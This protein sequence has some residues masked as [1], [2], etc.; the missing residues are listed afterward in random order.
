MQLGRCRAWV[1]SLSTMVHFPCCMRQ[2]ALLGGA[3]RM[4]CCTYELPATSAPGFRCSLLRP[5]YC[6]SLKRGPRLRQTRQQQ[7]SAGQRLRG[8][9]GQAGGS[10]TSCKACTAGAKPCV[11]C[12]SGLQTTRLHQQAVITLG[13]P[14]IGACPADRRKACWEWSR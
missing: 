9:R 10:W 3:F 12:L 4:H 7:C 2:D 1:S 8:V 14:D 13:S 11:K 5:W 6:S